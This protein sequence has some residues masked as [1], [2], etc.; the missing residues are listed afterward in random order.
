[1]DASFQGPPWGEPETALPPSIPTESRGVPLSGFDR[2][3]FETMIESPDLAARAV[4][5]VNPEW[6]DT[7]A[8]K[9]D[10]FCIPRIGSGRSRAGSGVIVCLLLENDFL[11]NE[12]VTL[13]F[14]LT[15]REGKIAQSAEE[16][17]HV[18]DRAVRSNAKTAA[19]KHRQI[20]KLESASLDENEELEVLKQLFEGEKSRQQIDQ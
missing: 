2:E 11:K 20:A 15:Q 16:T 8:G 19:E 10:T 7:L 13:Q 14:R 18:F 3:L 17:I 12:I 4:E 9:N 1:M 6:L 5:T